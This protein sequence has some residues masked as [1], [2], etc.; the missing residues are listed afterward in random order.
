[1]TFMIDLFCLQG[2][3]HCKWIEL[4]GTIFLPSKSSDWKEHGGNLPLYII[5]EDYSNGCATI[6]IRSYRCYGLKKSFIRTYEL[7]GKQTDEIDTEI[8]IFE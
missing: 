7:M 3:I 4:E 5:R 2:R 1:M 6:M 8:I